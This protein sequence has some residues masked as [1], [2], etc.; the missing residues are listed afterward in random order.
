MFPQ[1]V[2]FNQAVEPKKG[3]MVNSMDKTNAISSNVKLVLILASKP[4]YQP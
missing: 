1:S 3:T 4:D 2:T